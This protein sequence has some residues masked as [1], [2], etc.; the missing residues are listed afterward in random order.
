M[1][2]IWINYL[3][4]S[5]STL[6]SQFLKGQGYPV[7][8]E[9]RVYDEIAK[10]CS[11]ALDNKIS[12]RS[13][14]RIV[15]VR[16]SEKTLLAL[17]GRERR[18]ALKRALQFNSDKR[19]T[20]KEAI[21]TIG[22]ILLD[23]SS[24]TPVLVVKRG[25]FVDRWKN[26]PLFKEIFLINLFRHPLGIY[27]S[28]SNTR[29]SSENSM[30][31]NGK[32][33]YGIELF[34]FYFLHIVRVLCIGRVIGISVENFVNNPEK[35]IKFLKSKGFSNSQ[36]ITQQYSLIPIGTEHA[37]GNIFSMPSERVIWGWLDSTRLKT[38]HLIYYKFAL[39]TFLVNKFD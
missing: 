10:I 2:I 30:L 4:R 26:I 29:H 8:P 35:L 24:E 12:A 39:S 9:S 31:L 33:G 13:L 34:R 21:E 16:D 6:V 20:F 18:V 25:G 37:H 23:L 32:W 1:Q 22:C 28:Q 27:L 3:S 15:F 38:L 36:N 19:Y 14:K 17:F 7:L 5:G 11:D